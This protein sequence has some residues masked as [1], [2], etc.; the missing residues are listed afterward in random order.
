MDRYVETHVAAARSQLGW[1]LTEHPLLAPFPPAD[2]RFWLEVD[3][4]VALARRDTRAETPT[5]DEHAIGLRGYAREFHRLARQ[6]GEIRLDA[7]ASPDTNAAYIA[8]R[9]SRVITDSSGAPTETN[10]VPPSATPRATSSQALGCWL[11]LGTAG[12]PA[13]VRAVPI[14]ELGAEV[15]ALRRELETWCGE[16][17]LGVPEREWLEAYWTTAIL[18]L[19]TQ[20]PSEA[21]LALWP[22]ALCALRGHTD[23]SSLRDLQLVLS[24]RVQVVS[25]INSAVRYEETFHR[26]GATETAAKRLSAGYVAELGRIARAEGWPAPTPA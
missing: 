23:L 25:W 4:N 2:L 7:G 13:D 12:G 19:R 21:R 18:D 5:A 15:F 1:D 10:L 11:H 16:R 3:P 17:A 9:T 24:A 6:T 20:D 26:L 14:L 8:D 22:G